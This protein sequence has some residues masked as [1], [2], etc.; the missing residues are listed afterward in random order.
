MPS[1][2]KV[3]NRLVMGSREKH[4]ANQA[5]APESLPRSRPHPTAAAPTQVRNPKIRKNAPAQRHSTQSGRR[6]AF[7]AS[8]TVCQKPRPVIQPPV[9]ASDATALIKPHILSRDRIARTSR[10]V[11]RVAP[12]FAMLRGRANR[13]G[14]PQKSRGAGGDRTPA[15]VS[16]EVTRRPRHESAQ[17]GKPASRREKRTSA[18][19]RNKG[20]CV[21]LSNADKKKMSG[22]ARR[23]ISCDLPDFVCPHP[24]VRFERWIIR[25]LSA[26]PDFTLMGS[27]R[28]GPVDEKFSIV[29]VSVPGSGKKTRPS[30]SKELAD[31]NVHFALLANEI[32]A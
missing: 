11:M 5:S 28:A 13:F 18:A 9:L 3:E 23:H 10:I 32:F 24:Q 27:A 4:R 21:I 7:A 25:P 12:G 17:N 29:H 1:F 2:S 8:M 30:C 26:S 20:Q 19:A 31:G 15:C 22:T 14:F 16:F 6:R